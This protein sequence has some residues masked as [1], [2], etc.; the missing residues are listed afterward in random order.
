MFKKKQLPLL[1]TVLLLAIATCTLCLCIVNRD[2]F[3]ERLEHE[4]RRLPLNISSN[5]YLKMMVEISIS[6]NIDEAYRMILIL[7]KIRPQTALPGAINLMSNLRNSDPPSTA[8]DGFVYRS[9]ESNYSEYSADIFTSST[10]VTSA[11][12]DIV[13]YITHFLEKEQGL[14]P[15][16]GPCALILS[17]IGWRSITSIRIL[18]KLLVNNDPSSIGSIESAISKI[19]R[20]YIVHL[21]YSLFL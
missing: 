5:P 2:D 16:H 10:Q 13:P 15:V 7:H 20:E 17:K 18:K 11:D 4:A 8:F 9:A 1:I 14:A 6:N 3:Y 21:S 12:A 19:E